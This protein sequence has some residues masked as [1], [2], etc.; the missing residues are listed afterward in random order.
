MNAAQKTEDLAVLLSPDRSESLRR[1]VGQRRNQTV[2][3]QLELVIV[4]PSIDRFALDNNGLRDF[5]PVRVVE[6]YPG[7]SI[8]FECSG[9]LLDKLGRR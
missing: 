1:T 2:T 3:D 7:E 5:C 4:A 9:G 6:F 8:R